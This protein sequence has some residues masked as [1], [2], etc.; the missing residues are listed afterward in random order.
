MGNHV[1]KQSSSSIG[2]LSFLPKLPRRHA[3]KWRHRYTHSFDMRTR[4]PLRRMGGSNPSDELFFNVDTISFA[5]SCLGGLS[6]FRMAVSGCLGAVVGSSPILLASP[7]LLL[8]GSVITAVATSSAAT[9]YFFFFGIRGSAISSPDASLGV[10]F[11]VA[12]L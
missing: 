5:T 10:L 12:D 3:T 7:I 2:D 4:S 11:F 6:D 1:S 9:A 8:M